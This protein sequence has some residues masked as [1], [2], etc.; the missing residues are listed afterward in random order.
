[1]LAIQDEVIALGSEKDR[2]GF[3]KQDERKAVSILGSA[4][5]EEFIRIDAILN[6]ASDQGKD[7]KNDGRAMRIWEPYLSND[8]GDDR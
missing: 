5:K 2:R 8:V 4:V 3:T 1:M 6:S 7:V